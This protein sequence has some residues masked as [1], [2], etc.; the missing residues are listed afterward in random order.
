MKHT[1][2]W[3]R[4]V[5]V[6]THDIRCRW[7]RYKAGPFVWTSF[8]R[9][10]APLAT[11]LPDILRAEEQLLILISFLLAEREVECVDLPLLVPVW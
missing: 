6:H 10:S 3:Q 5:L 7:N 9:D 1:S 2:L 11:I 8:P 4:G